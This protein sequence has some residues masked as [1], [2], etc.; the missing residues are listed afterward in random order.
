MTR[1]MVNSRLKKEFKVIVSRKEN[2]SKESKFWLEEDELNIRHFSFNILSQQEERCRQFHF[3][4]NQ[5]SLNP[6]KSP[7]KDYSRT[8]RI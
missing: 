7:R 6:K 4:N 2:V 1:L 5:V 8:R 3:E